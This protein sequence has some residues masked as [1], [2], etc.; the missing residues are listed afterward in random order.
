VPASGGNP[1]VTHDVLVIDMDQAYQQ[2]TQEF[3]LASDDNTA[4]LRWIA[5]LYYLHETSTLA[6]TSI[7]RQRLPGRA[8]FRRGIT[9][10]S[11]FDVIPNPYGNTSPSAS[12]T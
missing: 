11:L 2:F 9:P 12:T 10:P 1:Q 5:G 7:R 8:P 6:R 3:R 4:R